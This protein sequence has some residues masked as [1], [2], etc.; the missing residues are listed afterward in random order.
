MSIAMSIVARCFCPLPAGLTVRCTRAPRPVRQVLV[1]AGLAAAALSFARADD[2]AAWQLAGHQGLV[3]VVIVPAQ[4]ARD[5]SAYQAQLARLCP[6]DRTCF[7]NFYT[8]TA[9]ATPELPLPDAIANEATA[10]FRR[11]MKNGTE[12]FEWSCRL[13][14]REGQCF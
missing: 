7:V 6:A 10:R 12:V 11:S 13:G 9:G 1:T 4:Q 3:Q 5:A 2:L 14:V 8:N